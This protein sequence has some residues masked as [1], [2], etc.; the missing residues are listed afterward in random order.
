[1]DNGR[2]GDNED[3]L[4]DHLFHEYKG[5]AFLHIYHP[6]APPFILPPYPSNQSSSPQLSICHPVSLKPSFVKNENAGE[7]PADPI[8]N[9]RQQIPRSRDQTCQSIYCMAYI[10]AGYYMIRYFRSQHP[11]MP[12]PLLMPSEGHSGEAEVH[13]VYRGG[14]MA[15]AGVYRPLPL[16]W[17]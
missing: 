15:T 6:P 1:M 13:P 16:L 4:K 3:L 17:Y 11:D 10:L 9:G 8:G 14:K 5:A 7:Y 2:G 12:H